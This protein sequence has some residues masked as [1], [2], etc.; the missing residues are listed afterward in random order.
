[1]ETTYNVF[2]PVQLMVSRVARDVLYQIKSN[3]IKYLFPTKQYKHKVNGESIV[4][5]IITTLSIGKGICG[6]LLSEWATEV[7]SKSLFTSGAHL[8]SNPRCE[9]LCCS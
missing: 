9:W 2:S 4:H 8:W 1:M 3:Q 6:E 5:G 7:G